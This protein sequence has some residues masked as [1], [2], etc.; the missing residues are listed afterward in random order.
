MAIG[1]GVPVPKPTRRLVDRVA[2]RKA[3]DTRASRF[4]A[5]VLKRDGMRCRLCGRQVIR[6]LALVP[7]AAH[8]HH[9]KGRNV[10]PE[11]RYNA[12]KALLL[13]GRCHLDVHVGRVP[14]P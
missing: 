1:Y 4:R 7:N 11:D 5:D 13:C 12:K 9:L 2:Q 8:V 3:R 6:T 10:A 14:R